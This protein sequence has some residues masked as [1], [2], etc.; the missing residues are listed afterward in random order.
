M[1]ARPEAAVLGSRTLSD[2]VYFSALPAIKVGPGAT[3][4]SHAP[5]EF[6]NEREIVEGA[7]FYEALLRGYRLSS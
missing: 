2:W 3:E 4:R 6:V 5:D 1:Q 7:R